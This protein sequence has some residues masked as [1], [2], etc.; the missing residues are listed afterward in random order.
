MLIAAPTAPVETA[1][2]ILEIGLVLVMAVAAGWTARRIGLPAVLGYLLVGV[3]VSPFTPGYVVDREQLQLLAD[4]GVVILLFEVGIEINPRRLMREQRGL[5]LAAPAQ[6]AITTGIA[7][8]AGMALGIGRAAAALL[9]VAIALSSSVVVVNITRSRRR[10]TNGATEQALLSWSVLQDMTGVVLALLML[11]AFHLGQ[12]PPAVAALLIAA[13]AA[14]SAAAAWLL[15][16]LL[17]SLRAEHDLFLLL[18]VGSGLVLAGV[19]A[20]FF[21]VPLALAAFVA[22][23]AVGESPAAAEARRRLLPFRDLFAAMF[24]VSLGTLLDFAAVPGALPW[25]GFMLGGVALAKA[26][27]ALLLSRA[28]KLAPDVRRW[29]LAVGLAQIGEFSFVIGSILL[30]QALIGSQVFTAL[31]VTVVVTVVLSTVLVRVGPAAPAA[32]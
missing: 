18:S 15:P 27:P 23:L 21:G 28:A 11:A 30:A 10:V 22:G 31:L 17:S 19:G 14:V 20:K 13:Y 29:Q 26:L 1:P 12:R 5:L 2:G 6:M 9:G 32:T 16:R 7:A 8:A 25:V 4:V 24:F 3:V